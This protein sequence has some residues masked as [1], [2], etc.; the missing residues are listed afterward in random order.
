MGRRRIT[1]ATVQ[2]F[3]VDAHALPFDDESFSF[4]FSAAVLEHL[5]FPRVAMAEL[6]R[7]MKPGAWFLGTVAFLEPYHSRSHFHH[8]HLGTLSVLQRAGFD[9]VSVSPGRRTVIKAQARNGL[10]PGM[11]RQAALGLVWPLDAAHRLWWRM[12]RLRGHPMSE[13]ERLLRLGGA[14]TFRARKPVLRV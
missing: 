10:F 7:V 14:F 11:P 12:M 9:V 4:A 8:S 2:T 3:L 5:E 6:F 1:P 13:D